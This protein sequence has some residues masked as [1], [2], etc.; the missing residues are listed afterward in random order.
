MV[1][2][3]API[4]E[5]LGGKKDDDGTTVEE[6]VDY[7]IKSDYPQGF[8][9]PDDDGMSQSATEFKENLVRPTRFEGSP[10]HQFLMKEIALAVMSS[11]E[12]EDYFGLCMQCVSLAE[13]LGLVDVRN[14]L[15]AQME[16]ELLLTR[17]RKGKQLELS[18]SEGHRIEK[19]VGEMKGGGWK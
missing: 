16:F 3:F 10:Y 19:V 5:A 6:R 15:L 9:R 13:S 18:H 4:R 7:S 1:D 17:G 8:P 11:D 14:Q 12:D 2:L